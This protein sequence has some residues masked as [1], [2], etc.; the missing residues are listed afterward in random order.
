MIRPMS[1]VVSEQRD[2]SPTQ[3]SLVRGFNLSISIVHVTVSS[4]I[5]AYLTFNCLRVWVMG[6]GNPPL[7]VLGPLEVKPSHV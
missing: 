2:L 6:M 4:L 1:H 7:M 5:C 3:I